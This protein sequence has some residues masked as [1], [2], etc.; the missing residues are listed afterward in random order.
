MGIEL[1][2]SREEIAADCVTSIA[3]P[4]RLTDQKVRFS[5]LKGWRNYVCLARLETF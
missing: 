1:W 2:A 3:L 5:L 4:D